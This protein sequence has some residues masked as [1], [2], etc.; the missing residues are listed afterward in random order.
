[1]SQV[2]EQGLPE[3][4]SDD[5]AEFL[6]AARQLEEEAQDFGGS[7]GNGNSLEE[8]RNIAYLPLK[9]KDWVIYRCL[10]KIPVAIDKIT[11]PKSTQA[12]EINKVELM[13]DKNK[14]NTYYIPDR[15]KSNPKKDHVFWRIY[16][17]I[18]EFEWDKKPGDLKAS[19]VYRYEHAFPALFTFAQNGGFPG[20]QGEF[21]RGLK[22]KRIVIQ[23]VID[24]NDPQWHK[25]H[26][27][28]KL[29]ARTCSEYTDK[30]TGETKL[31]Y[32][33]GI[34][35]FGYLTLWGSLWQNYGNWEKY[36][37]AAFRTG[38]TQPAMKLLNASEYKTKEIIE[39]PKKFW[40][41]VVVGPLTDEEI[42]YERY[43]IARLFGI[44]TYTKILNI[45][46]RLAAIDEAFNTH[47]LEEVQDYS[48]EEKKKWKEEGK[49]EEGGETTSS[50]SIVKEEKAPMEEKV[51]EKVEKPV[52]RR[53]VA[54]ETT[55][56]DFSTILKGWAKLSEA[57]KA[58]IID[59]EQVDG[60]IV[61]KYNSKKELVDCPKCNSLSPEDFMA[62]PSCGARFS[63]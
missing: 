4:M 8:Y 39:L 25:E 40:P 32:D 21:A 28:S 19:K 27:H 3:G 47:F 15:N 2:D 56:K 55:K 48:S 9:S 5:D 31:F 30:K 1:M 12:I 13:S 37:V 20:K 6:A 22:G 51:E 11:D 57:E 23:N 50:K 61:V 10:G 33:L 45:K 59:V 18:T 46:E 52:S 29:L 38:V 36:D 35:T 62:C 7:G 63:V 60:K 58:Q 41:Q 24:R 44:S 34:S 16:D 42:K 14:K 49:D 54:D 53:A 43:E 26:Q 17:K